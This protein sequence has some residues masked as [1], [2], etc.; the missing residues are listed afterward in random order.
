MPFKQTKKMTDEKQL[1]DVTDHNIAV[2][3]QDSI[4]LFKKELSTTV[5]Y[6]TIQDIWSQRNLTECSI[7]VMI[8]AE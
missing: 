8:R 3:L 5:S 7:S 6:V 4:A 2:L 1:L